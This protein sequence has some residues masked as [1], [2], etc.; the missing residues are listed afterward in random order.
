MPEIT[1]TR[2]EKFGERMVERVGQCS[3]HS[4]RTTHASSRSLSPWCGAFTSPPPSRR[5]HGW[6][7]H[8]LRPTPQ[9]PHPPRVRSGHPAAGASRPNAYGHS[10]DL[11]WAARLSP[12][13]APGTLDGPR[14]QSPSGTRPGALPLAGPRRPR[15]PGPFPTSRTALSVPGGSLGVPGPGQRPHPLCSAPQRPHPP[16]PT[17]PAALPGPIQPTW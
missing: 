9:I 11:P 12:A 16:W 2:L 1:A 13:G 10:C 6:L 4:D 8:S 14:T 3:R 5:R 7:L 17:P 15:A